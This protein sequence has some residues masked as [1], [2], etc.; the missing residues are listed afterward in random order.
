[1]GETD[2]CQPLQEVS[3]NILETLTNLPETPAG[4]TKIYYYLCLTGKY[5]FFFSP[6]ISLG[7]R[8]ENGKVSRDM[9]RYISPRSAQ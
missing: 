3:L 1:M 4:V 8:E 7:K 9:N 2:A 6:L 5:Q